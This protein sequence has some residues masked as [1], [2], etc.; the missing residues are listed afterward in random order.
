[1]QEVIATVEALAPEAAGLITAEE[2]PLPFPAEVDSTSFTELVG[3]PVTRPLRDGVADA[4]QRFER[5][6]AAGLVAPPEPA[7][8]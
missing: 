5:L 6:L 1:M 3:G 7:T 2:E 8:A 4:L